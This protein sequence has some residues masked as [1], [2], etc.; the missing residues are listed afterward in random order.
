[1]AHPAYL[2]PRAHCDDPNRVRY[3]T[4]LFLFACASAVAQE[5]PEESRVEAIL[6]TWRTSVTGTLQSG[7]LPVDLH[8]DLNLQPAW[9]FYGKLTFKPGRRHRIFA[10][11]SPYAFDGTNALTRTINFRGVDYTVSDRV[12]SS[13]DMTWINAG[14][15]FDLLSRPQGHFG[16]QIS[17]A[18]VDA[19][20]R[21]RSETTGIQASRSQQL[22]LPLAGAEFRA[23]LLPGRRLLSVDGQVKG[24]AFGGYGH[25]VQA[26]GGVG[27][28]I[29][30]LTVRAGYG[31]LDADIH[32]SRSTS[33]PGIAPRFAGPMLSLELR[34]R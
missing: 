26:M 6:S 3:I 11:G 4:L 23:W 32:E 2:K 5:D 33:P 15:Q 17:G 31:V 9:T 21:I 12:T 30:R 25:F 28:G 19:S 16:L 7:I 29:R 22:G 10:E 34:D 18:Y 24:M 27:V 8:R 1:M 13:A 20:G 14:Y